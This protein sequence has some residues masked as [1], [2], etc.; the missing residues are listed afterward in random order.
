VNRDGT[1][2]RLLYPHLDAM[3]IAWGPAALPPAGC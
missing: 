2:L 3:Q 1:G